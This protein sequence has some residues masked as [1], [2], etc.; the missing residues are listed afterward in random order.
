MAIKLVKLAL[1][2]NYSKKEICF[3]KV[4]FY[5]SVENG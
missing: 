1:V 2:C 4:F 3:T 5:F